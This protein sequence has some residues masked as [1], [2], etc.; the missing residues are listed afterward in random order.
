MI[1][2]LALAQRLLRQ[3]RTGANKLYSLHAPEVE[4]ISKGKA[5]KRYEFGVKVGWWLVSRSRSSSP[6][7]HC[8]ADPTMATP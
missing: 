1:R 6:R 5:H 2:E 7:M 4:C 8:R 3:K